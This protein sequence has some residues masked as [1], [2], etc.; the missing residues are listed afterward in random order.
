[1]SGSNNNGE[2]PLASSLPLA[3]PFLAMLFSPSLPLPHFSAMSEESSLSFDRKAILL[4]RNPQQG[5]NEDVFMGAPVP[6]GMNAHLR[7]FL[8]VPPSSLN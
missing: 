1:M 4:L 6:L 7:Q 8:T 5:A 3:S 2:E